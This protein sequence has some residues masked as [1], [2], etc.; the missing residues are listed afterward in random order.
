M[1]EDEINYKNC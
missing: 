1:L